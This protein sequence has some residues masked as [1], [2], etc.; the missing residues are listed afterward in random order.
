MHSNRQTLSPQSLPSSSGDHTITQ[1]ALTIYIDDQNLLVIDAKLI[2][3][4]FASELAE[5]LAAIEGDI[6][7]KVDQ[8]GL[9]SDEPRGMLFELVRQVGERA[10][11]RVGD[12]TFATP[13]EAV[14]ASMVGSA[15]LAALAK[16][17]RAAKEAAAIFHGE[18]P[19]VA[20]QRINQRLTDLGAPKI[21][22][23]TL[24]KE[25]RQLGGTEGSTAGTTGNYGDAH[26][27]ATAFIA[28]LHQRLDMQDPEQPVL[29]YYRSEFFEFGG[30]AW[31]RLEDDRLSARIGRFLHGSQ[32]E[33]AITAKLVGDVVTC[34]QALTLIDHW[35]N[36]LPFWI[37]LPAND[38]HDEAGQPP[39]TLVLRNGTI[40]LNH[41]A[42]GQAAEVE[43]H[44]SRFFNT[45]ALSFDYESHATCPQFTRFL[46]QILPRKNS[47]DRRREVLQ[48][49]FAYT[50]LHDCRFQKM[51]AMV[52]FGANGKSTLMEVW[53]ALLGAGNV[54][55]TEYSQ[56]SQEFRLQD[57]YGKA[58]NFSSEI[59]HLGRAREGL[60]KQ[61]IAG[62]P[63]TA[64][65]KHKIPITFRSFAKLV[66]ACNEL[67]TITDRTGG[68]WRRLIVI[69]FEVTIPNNQMNLDL[70]AQL[71]VELPGI[72]NW[73]AVG[74]RR[75]LNNGHFTEC[76]V[77]TAA[78]QSH[79]LRSDSV[80]D[81]IVNHCVRECGW[82]ARSSRLYEVYRF[83]TETMGGI[84][85][86]N[87]VFGEVLKAS[88]IQHRRAT[89][90]ED[91]V[92][93]WVYTGIR[94]SVTGQEWCRRYVRQRSPGWN[95]NE[96]TFQVCASPS[97][98]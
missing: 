86:K 97:S 23:C 29:A 77:C 2:D 30:I 13:F 85:V 20:A 84:P 31:R 92:R 42:D 66:V 50:L 55:R 38:F 93:P 64:N 26:Q 53:E 24:V 37:E 35:I 34:L 59:D 21:R 95:E 39:R 63:I 9:W 90:T 18:I 12:V 78:L 70:A 94:F 19:E 75:L 96:V 47:T 36:D 45:V 11:L 48:E 87:N 41:L 67:P 10:R 7:L 79:R 56:L 98:P 51:L 88:R 49:F 65:R 32:A 43:S 28:D 44:D 61:L 4:T 1:A 72:L 8:L 73:A 6:T 25:I 22:K 15:D 54:S 68:M 76:S 74:L 89:P 60:L 71:K 40:D 80:A 81:F 91:P 58:A 46:A 62:E 82:D 69:P 52:G 33:G 27:I 17:L 57:L 83:A 16:G 14:L 3:A 5:Q